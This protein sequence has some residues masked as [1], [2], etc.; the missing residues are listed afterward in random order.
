MVQIILLI[1]GVVYVIRR[2]KL[3]RLAPAD[4][5]TVPADQFAAWKRLELASIDIFLW[6]TWGLATIGTVIVFVVSVVI[7]DA[8]PSRAAG[9]Q[10]RVA[11]T[12]IL[13]C[14]G[15]LLLVGLTISAIRGSQAAKLRNTLGIRWP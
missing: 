10:I 8:T 2:P 12:I 11:E 13:G 14:N 7:A 1:L 6:S 4:F 3:S 5:P 9:A 15:L